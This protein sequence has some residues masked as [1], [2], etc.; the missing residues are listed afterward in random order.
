LG[1]LSL[2]FYVLAYNISGWPV[3]VFGLMINEVALPAF[4]RAQED[5]Q[6]LQVRVAGAFALTAAV[7]LPVN[8]LCVAVAHPLVQAVYGSR[9]SAAG[10]ALAVLGLFGSM[11]IIVTLMNNILAALGHT[12]AVFRLQLVWIFALVPSLV[13]CVGWWGIVGAAIAQEIVAV[14]VVVP[15]GLLLVVKAGGG[16]ASQILRGC[17]LPLTASVVSGVLAWTLTLLTSNVFLKVAVAT[18]VGVVVYVLLVG[19]WALGLLREARSH[20]NESD[21]AALGSTETVNDNNSLHSRR[22]V[23]QRYGG[24]HRGPK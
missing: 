6:S 20:W 5:I 2:G 19:R 23:R 12:H 3:S 16:K 8:A 13:V 7:A 11:R 24:R 22:P 4:A 1:A 17:L 14:I 10:P 15:L 9:W 21:G 18:V